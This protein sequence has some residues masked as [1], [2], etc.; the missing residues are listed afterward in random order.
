MKVGELVEVSEWS[1]VIGGKGCPRAVVMLGD[2]EYVR[3]ALVV[4]ID[5]YELGVG[6]SHP[7]AFRVIAGCR[8]G[9]GRTIR[10]AV[11]T[12]VMR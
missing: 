11:E 6:A 7:V 8:G 4:P 2:V 5:W 12:E 3:V 9:G 10:R 1:D